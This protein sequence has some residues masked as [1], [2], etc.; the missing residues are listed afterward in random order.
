MTSTRH[1][2]ADSWRRLAARPGYLGFAVTV[3][4]ARIVGAMFNTAGIVFV[5]GRTGS[6]GLTGAMAAAVTLPLAVAGPWLGAWL[7]LAPRRRPLIVLDNLVSVVALAALLALAGHGPDW[8]LPLCGVLLGITRPLSAGSFSSAVSVLAGPELLDR[9]S[10]VEATSL[11]LS[12]VIGPALAGV[13]V[14]V[15][16]AADVVALQAALTIV[17]TVA[18]A[19]NPSFEARGPERPRS[20]GH[21]VREG[22]RALIGHRLLRD[23]LVGSVLANVSWGLM[24]IVFPLW[25]EG[26]LHGRA[27]AGGYLWAA[28]AGGSVVGIFARPG[29]P[30]RARVARSYLLLGLSAALWRLAGSVPAA[31]GLVLLS[32]IL[33]GPAYSGT[34]ALRQ[35]HAPPHVRAQ[36]LNTMQ[37]LN[38]AAAAVGSVAGG[39]LHRPPYAFVAFGGLNLLAALIMAPGRRAG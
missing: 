2:P 37:S 22:T 4:I 31:V 6:A 36:V 27:S 38:M 20:L 33:E 13:L 35:R 23:T 26:E 24:I 17:V 19:A 14:G 9:A 34:I 29:P 8:T 10:A 18:V 11:N 39:L 16:G 30:S 1:A 12:I 25:A 15:L 28:L 7:D 3:S 5:L 21:A 32:G